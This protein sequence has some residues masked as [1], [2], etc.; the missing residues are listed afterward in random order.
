MGGQIREVLTVFTP[1]CNGI[2]LTE[3][4]SIIF[5]FN[6][7]IEFFFCPFIP[8]YLKIG[9]INVLALIR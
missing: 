4:R 6:N 9:Q 5:V 3:I 8:E 7:T 1:S 2:A